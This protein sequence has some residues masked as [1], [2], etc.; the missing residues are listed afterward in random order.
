MFI[1]NS[2]FIAVRISVLYILLAFALCGAV[3]LLSVLFECYHFYKYLKN[4]KTLI[5]L[6]SLSMV[7]KSNK[8]PYP[9][10]SNEY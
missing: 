5:S 4:K 7:P 6:T 8:Q 1:L 10:Q 2:S 3:A 9:V